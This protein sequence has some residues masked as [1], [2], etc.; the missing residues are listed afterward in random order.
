[1]GAGQYELAGGVCHIVPVPSWSDVACNGP[2][3]GHMALKKGT[4]SY[5]Y[6]TV[7]LDALATQD[8]F[9]MP[10]LQQQ[11]KQARV[12]DTP[13]PTTYPPL[14]N[15]VTRLLLQWAQGNTSAQ[16]VQRLAH[17]ATTD[18]LLHPEVVAMASMGSW[19]QVP[20]NCN[21]D[22]KRAYPCD[23]LPLPTTVRVP[24]L[25]EKA[26][27]TIVVH[28]DVGLM[29]PHLWIASIA[30]SHLADQ[31]LGLQSVEQFWASVNQ[32]DPRLQ[33]RGGHPVLSVPNYNSSVVPLWL[34]GDGVEYAEDESLM[35]LTFGS[36]LAT[37]N[38][39]DSMF[40]MAS[41]VKAVTATQTKHGA[42]TWDS[43]WKVLVWS[44]K[45]L[46]LGTHPTKDWNDEDFEV[47]SLFLQKAGQPL[48]KNFRFIIWNLL[49][50]WEY[51][52]NHLHLPHWQSHQ[53]CWFCDCHKVDQTKNWKVCWPGKGWANRDPIT[54]EHPST[55]PVFSL[56]GV[57]SWCVCADMLHTLE[58]KGVASHLLGSVLHQL[59]LKRGA[60]VRAA[61]EE[62]GKLWRRIQELY[63]LMGVS[64]R[65]TNLQLSMLCDVQRPFATYPSLHA[66]A[67]ETR[68]LVPVV[69]A[70]LEG[71]CG[72]TPTSQHRVAAC[73]ELA[74][75][76]QV[77][78]AE[79]MFMS[80]Q[81]SM[82]SLKHMEA[83]LVHYAWLERDAHS[84][85]ELLYNIVPKFHMCW[86]LADH[87][88]FMNARFCWTYKCESWVG[89][90]SHLA[91][92]CAH[93][94]KMSHL[95]LSLAEKI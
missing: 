58:G 26:H 93:V 1:M 10:G 80:A 30:T 27:P 19:G 11:L 63:S 40:W 44:F 28:T 78:D 86:H 59:V 67:A 39:M 73:R 32:H 20:G 83:M 21:R 49:G 13:A 71:M 36:V 50:D 31:L 48:Y 79:P 7:V 54:W 74:L 81:A 68:H 75:F 35:T 55:H 92:S 61:S 72:G 34:H 9:K 45:A 60:G 24:C 47:G 25:S 41:F 46:W 12:S 95:S 84:R 8:W 89:K 52:A 91:A 51:F 90:V 6:T 17:A 33:A 42:D 82:A 62:L 70:L 29:L 57:T 16:E 3:E 18:G 53:M 76:Y 85:G 2:E 94:T 14:S 64:E 88:R 23:D 15:L 22:L 43:I 69:A 38:S 77:C 56:P 66:K 5:L 65:L 87:N 4:T 37:T